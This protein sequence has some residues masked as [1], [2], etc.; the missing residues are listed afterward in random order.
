MN[1]NYEFLLSDISKLKNVGKKTSLIFKKKKVNTIFDLLWR[2]PQNYT[3]RS[4]IFK[5]KDLH[6]GKISTLEIVPLKYNFPRIRNLPNKVICEDETG[7]LDCIFFNSYKGYIRKILPLNEK[8]TISGK[9]SFFKNRYQITNPTYVSKDKNVI[10]KIHNKYSLTE[11]ITE[12]KYNSIIN[13]ILDNLPDLD[14]WHHPNITKLFSNL[15]WKESIVKL[16]D[17]KNIGEQNSKFYKRLAFDEILSSFLVFS[18]IRKSIKKIK[19]NKKIFTNKYTDKTIKNFGFKLTIDQKKALDEINLD[20]FSKS[21]MFRMLQGDV[22]SGKTIVALLSSLNVIESG[23]QVAFMAPTEILANQH[24]QLA[25]KLFPSEIKINLL[26]SKTDNFNKKK[27][28][29]DL[30]KSQIQMIFG[31]HALFQKKTVFKKLGYIIID[32]QHKFG[33]KQRKSL[34]DKGGSNCDILLMS[35]TP[36]PRTLTM[37]IY[38]DMDLSIIKEKPKNRKEVITYSKSEEKIN[39]VLSFVKKEIKDNNQIFWVCPLI[40]ESKKVDHQS[41]I[42]KFKFL[43]KLFPTKVA[44]IHSKIDQDK[45]ELILRNFL[46]K[47]YDILVSTT[48]IEVGIDFPN[49]NVIVIEN[50]NKFGLSQLHQLRGRVGRGIKQG[51]CILMFKNNLSENAKKRIK[52]LK[53]SN[54]GFVISEEDMKLRGFGDILGFKQSGEKKYNLADPIIHEDLFKIAEEEIKRIEIEEKNLIKY[55]PLIKLYDRADI[56]NDLA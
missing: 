29:S 11:G 35:A 22:G 51:K 46:D 23:Y 3:D 6:I 50:S 20:L 53:N 54:N 16:H 12:K 26:T 9:V 39:D 18:E 40:E 36:I 33:V 42:Q 28:I 10:K 48:I 38:G 56:I 31:T 30:N 52:I 34:S 7:K 4:N 43:E 45:K 37:A 14:E 1:N 25:K 2:L 19:K 13:Q 21:K 27:I 15:K 24:F 5:I 44:I 55:K 17:F 8:I 49:A 32:E 47:K 41:A